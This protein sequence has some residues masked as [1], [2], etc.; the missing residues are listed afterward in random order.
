MR[1]ADVRPLGSQQV[2]SPGDAVARRLRVCGPVETVSSACSS[3]TLAIGLGL[4][5]IRDGEADLAVVGGA[6]TLCRTT[7]GGFNALGAVDQKPCTPFRA[8]RAGL[9]LGEGGAA[10]VLE[11]LDAA[12]ARGAAPLGELAGAGASCDAHHMTAPD[13]EGRGAALALRRALDD[14]ALPPSAVDAINAHGTGTPH[15]DLAEYR[16]IADVFGE[17]ASSIPLTATKASVGHLLGSSGAIE[18]VV[19][20]LSLSQQCVPPTPGPAAVDP[21]IP[22]RLVVGGPLAARLEVAVSVN[23]AFGGC[24]GALVFRRRGAD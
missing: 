23:L 22:V 3:A 9:S 24:N 1:D 18:A 19:T 4:A 13:P 2:S 5:A 20:V 11:S 7:F 14:A 15:N 10:L 8:S 12:L 6:D 16:A 21:E 17:R